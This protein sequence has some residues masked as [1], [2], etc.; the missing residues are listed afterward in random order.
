MEWEVLTYGLFAPPSMIAVYPNEY[1]FLPVVWP[2][3]PSQR[4]TEL[5]LEVDRCTS[6][7]IVFVDTMADVH[8]RGA[9]SGVNAISVGGLKTECSIFLDI[10]RSNEFVVGHELAHN[11]KLL[12]EKCF[13]YRCL[14]DKSDDRKVNLGSGPRRQRFSGI[15]RL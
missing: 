7:E 5:F 10:A 13:D 4:L 2:L 14:R 1:N 8:P 3:N 11:W 9:P 6:K 12:V 15:S